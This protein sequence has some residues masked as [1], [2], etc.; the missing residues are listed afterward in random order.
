MYAAQWFATIRKST[1][2]LDARFAA[3]DLSPAFDWLAANIWSQGSR[4][5]LTELVKRASGE[6]LNPGHF[7]KHVEERYLG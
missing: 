7:R 3:G 6:S 4:W 2:D 1:P 5:E